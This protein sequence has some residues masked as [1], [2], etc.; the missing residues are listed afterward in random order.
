M[1]TQTLLLFVPACFALAMAFGPNNLLAVTTSARHGMRTAVI[2]ATGRLIAF[3]IMIFMTALGL[4]VLLTTSEL[5]FAA[6]KWVGAAYLVWIGAR[7]LLTKESIGLEDRV[8]ASA[9]NTRDLF[10][11]EFFVA[12]GNPK[13]ILIFTAFFPQFIAPENYWVS[14]ATVGSLYLVFEGVSVVTYAFA[15]A[16]LRRFM[17]SARGL[18]SVNRLSGAMMVVFGLALAAARR[19]A[20]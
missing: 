7:L 6:L 3:A 13:A 9:Q 10:R 17:R 15:G 12:L 8:V 1:T 5:L 11:Q 20:A 4:G 19:P 16:R 14:F 18:R 2:A